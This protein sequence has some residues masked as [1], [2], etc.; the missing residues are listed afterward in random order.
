V[1]FSDENTSA[2]YIK[3]VDM[4][5]RTLLMLPR[6]Q[7]QEG[8]DISSLTPG[9]YSIQLTDEKTKHVTVRKFVKE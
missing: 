3:V 1:K 4:A 9:I 6:P 7:L 5:S 8:I 2:Y